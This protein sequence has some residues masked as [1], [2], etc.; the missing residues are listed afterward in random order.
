MFRDGAAEVRGAQPFVVGEIAMDCERCR[1]TV[2]GYAVQLTATE[3][4]FLRLPSLHAGMVVTHKNPLR[5]ARPKRDNPHPNLVRILVR[6]LRCKRGDSAARPTYIVNE[7]GVGYRMP[8]LG[9]PCPP[10]RRKPYR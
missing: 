8:E 9:E 10:A 7:R 6:Y 1:V 4:E 2:G 3:Y 5:R